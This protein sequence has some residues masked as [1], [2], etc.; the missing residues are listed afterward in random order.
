[1]M[2]AAASLHGHHAGLYR[3]GEGRNALRPHAPSLDDRPSLIQPHEAAAVLAQINS[4]N[5]DLHGYT[6]P[7]GRPRQHRLPGKEGRAIP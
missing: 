3:L 1:M 5:R 4:E 2:R 6:F 7:S